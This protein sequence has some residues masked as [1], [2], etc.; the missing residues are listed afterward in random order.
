MLLGAFTAERREAPT[1]T[2]RI[3]LSIRE[4]RWFFSRNLNRFTAKDDN[5]IGNAITNE[6]MFIIDSNSKVTTADGYTVTQPMQ[7]YLPLILN[8]WSSN[9][10][11]SGWCDKMIGSL[12]IADVIR[13]I[14]CTIS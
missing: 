12:S 10:P 2:P 14:G 1:D 7:M 8:M 11:Q 3:T 9:F 13:L 6:F 4:S 5:A